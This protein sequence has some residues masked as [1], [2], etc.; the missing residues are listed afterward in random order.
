MPD[1]CKG[2]I[3]HEEKHEDKARLSARAVEFWEKTLGMFDYPFRESLDNTWS[4][5]NYLNT[6]R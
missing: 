3:E 2:P 6:Y 5:V 1:D 4:K